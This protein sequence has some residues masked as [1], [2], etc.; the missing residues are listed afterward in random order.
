M[1]KNISWIY[2]TYILQSILQIDLLSIWPLPPILARARWSASPTR[3]LT[4]EFVSDATNKASAKQLRI[5]LYNTCYVN[6]KTN[7]WKNIAHNLSRSS[8]FTFRERYKRFQ[9]LKSS[10]Y[11]DNCNC[12]DCSNSIVLIIYC[13]NAIFIFHTSLFICGQ[14]L[15]WN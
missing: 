10:K 15:I 2:F 8:A 14:C 7:E 5:F 11:F 13:T 12:S 1:G 9:K 3:A 4:S 6:Y